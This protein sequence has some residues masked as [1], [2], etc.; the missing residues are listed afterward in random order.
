MPRKNKLKQS[1]RSSS[2]I[3]A[4]G[5]GIIGTMVGGIA[6]TLP[7]IIVGTT[8]GFIAD[9]TKVANMKTKPKKR[10]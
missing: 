1:Y 7:G 10:R 9:S 6:G 5:G 8:S 4:V 3:G 2:L